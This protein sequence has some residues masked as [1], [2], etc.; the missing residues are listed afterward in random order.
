MSDQLKKS[1]T[2]FPS[3]E[4]MAC[5]VSNDTLKVLLA[6]TASG[7]KRV[8]NDSFLMRIKVEQDGMAARTYEMVKRER[9][10]VVQEVVV[11]KSTQ[12][13]ARR[14]LDPRLDA[15]SIE[16]VLAGLQFV[17]DSTVDTQY[18]ALGTVHTIIGSVEEKMAQMK[19]ETEPLPS[20]AA[21]I[22][23]NLTRELDVTVDP[24]DRRALGRG[25]YALYRIGA[26][27]HNSVASAHRYLK[28]QSREVTLEAVLSY[29]NSRRL[30]SIANFLGNAENS[31]H[32]AG[33]PQDRL[34][35]LFKVL[36]I[37]YTRDNA[38]F[39][40]PRDPDS[41]VR[42]I[43]PPPGIARPFVA[44]LNIRHPEGFEVGLSVRRFNGQSGAAMISTVRM[45]DNTFRPAV[46]SITLN[47]AEAYRQA[48]DA[49]TEGRAPKGSIDLPQLPEYL[50]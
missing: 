27:A 26:M 14:I 19:T 40:I 8:G 22:V 5:E 16:R 11:D 39:L 13:E 43:D 2:E 35:Q 10:L 6:L 20:A 41:D 42:P 3:G 17:K 37:S 4:G 15:V 36:E 7:E 23:N 25:I 31:L 49:I 47:S 18:G 50:Q 32:S 24:S 38:D 28:E 34:S 46:C 21:F 44:I 33:V 9:G 12:A 1:I 45:T 29:T 48:Y 30:D